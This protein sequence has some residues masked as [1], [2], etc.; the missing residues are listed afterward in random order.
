MG[1]ILPWGQVDKCFPQ[2]TNLAWETID[3]S[4]PMPMAHLAKLD[5]GQIGKHVLSVS[6]LQFYNFY[7]F[8]WCWCRSI[9]QHRNSNS[10]HFGQYFFHL[11]AM[12]NNF[13]IYM[14]I[15]FVWIPYGMMNLKMFTLFKRNIILGKAMCQIIFSHRCCHKVDLWIWLQKHFI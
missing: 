5:S 1:P 12:K 3:P 15:C 2:R 10:N 13:A 8:Q 14:H 4:R 11:G 9:L 7:N 6:K